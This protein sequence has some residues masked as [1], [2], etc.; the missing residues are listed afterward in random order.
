MTFARLLF[1]NSATRQPPKKLL[2]RESVDLEVIVD[3]RTPTII[4]MAEHV[5]ITSSIKQ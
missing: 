1:S 3:G 5:E 2:D 4:G